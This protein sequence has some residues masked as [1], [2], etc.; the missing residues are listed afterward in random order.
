MAKLDKIKDS[1][2]EIAGRPKNVTFSEIRQVMEQLKE[3]GFT[4]RSRQAGD[5][6]TLF[7]IND[8][9]FSICTH[10]PGSKQLKPHYVK[11]F[12]NAMIELGLYD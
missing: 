9:V 2:R 5:H 6:A 7:H 10:N 11:E 3:H 12:V 1:I 4:V 8:Q